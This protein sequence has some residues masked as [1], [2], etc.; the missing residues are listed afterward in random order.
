MRTAETKDAEQPA[1]APTDRASYVSWSRDV[2]R[3]RDT[4]RQG[5][6]N[7]AVYATFLESGRTAMI[8]DPERP[9]APA[10]CAFVIA[11]LL[12]DYRAEVHWPGTVDIGTSVLRLG[13]SSM[14]L[15]QGVFIDETCVA[16]GETVLVLMDETTRKSRPFTEE[17]H[18]RLRPLAAP[19]VAL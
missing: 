4:D 16:S 8:Y 5:H 10:G 1:F 13:R 19:G 2:L 14:T 11:R 6:V 7:N 17:M 9:L 18:A 12:L 3:Y 15:A